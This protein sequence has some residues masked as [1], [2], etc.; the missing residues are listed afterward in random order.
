MRHYVDWERLKR[1]RWCV[2]YHCQNGCKERVRASEANLAFQ[3]FLQTFRV[4]PEVKE[5]YIA[6]IEDIFKTKE[7]NKEANWLSSKKN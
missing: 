3:G 4:Y 5:L 1:Q 7:G 2:Y 6:I